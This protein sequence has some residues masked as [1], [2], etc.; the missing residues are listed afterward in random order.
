[1]TG[2]ENNNTKV[3]GECCVSFMGLISSK[4]VENEENVSQSFFLFSSHDGFHF[5]TT[6]TTTMTT[7]TTIMMMMTR[8]RAR[9]G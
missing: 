8:E 9:A 7:M 1:M 2:A 3:V 6:F 5:C 4:A